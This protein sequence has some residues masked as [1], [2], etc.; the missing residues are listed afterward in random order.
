MSSVTPVRGPFAHVIQTSWLTMPA[1]ETV[2]GYGVDG[3]LGTS[4]IR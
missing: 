1:A 4:P 2:T 3:G